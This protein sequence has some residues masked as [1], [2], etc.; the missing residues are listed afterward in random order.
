M[1]EDNYKPL[2]PQIKEMLD[3]I[4]DALWEYKKYQ[5]NDEMSKAEE[6]LNMCSLSLDTILVTFDENLKLTNIN[7]EFMNKLIDKLSKLQEAYNQDILMSTIEDIYYLLYF[8]ENY[9]METGTTKH[10]EVESAKKKIMFVPYKASM[11][12]SMDSIYKAAINDESCEVFVV[13]APYYIV[14]DNNIT[15]YQYEGYE[16]DKSI[17]ITHW[18]ESYIYSIYFDVI[19]FHNPYDSYNTISRVHS[20]FQSNMLREWSKTLVFTPYAVGIDSFDTLEE[21]KEMYIANMFKLPALQYSDVVLAN[22]VCEKEFLKKQGIDE[23]K[24]FRASP[25]LDYVTTIQDNEVQIPQEWSDKL[26]GRTT[27]L[28]GLNIKHINVAYNEAIKIIV[29]MLNDTDCGLIF[30]PH[31]F[32]G[33]FLKGYNLEVFEHFQSVIDIIKRSSNGIYDDTTSYVTSFQASDALFNDFSSIMP[34]YM[35][36]GK[37]VYQ[38]IEPHINKK[39][40]NI[41]YTGAYGVSGDVSI[42]DFISLVK[43]NNDYK[44]EERLDKFYSSISGVEETNDTDGTRVHQYV[45]NLKS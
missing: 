27:F 31:P 29:D 8:A 35:M 26:Q 5:E 20:S 28:V 16:L 2:I 15:K 12:D 45:M 21:S 13:P 42:S 9:H 37:P 36:T 4:A 43:S 6:V 24:L 19:Y 44:K 10:Q 18:Q 41:D 7:I 14:K 38:Y 3:T 1:N 23:R 40:H 32:L 34:M 22:S 30:R 39:F 17:E 25:K 11:W 33:E